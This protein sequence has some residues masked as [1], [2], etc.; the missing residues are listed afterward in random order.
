M[1]WAVP[2]EPDEVEDA[3]AFML[4][5]LEPEAMKNPNRVGTLTRLMAM[6]DYTRAELLLAMRKVPMDSRASHNYGR[7]FNPADVHRVIAESR[8]LRQIVGTGEARPRKLTE[9]QMYKACDEHEELNPQDFGT[10]GFDVDD[11]PFYVYCKPGHRPDEKEWGSGF[12]AENGAT[13]LLPDR[14]DEGGGPSPFRTVD[15]P[16]R[17]DR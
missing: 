16:G 2:A 11:R 15:G 8:K 7:G 10:C 4:T 5:T 12:G 13:A 3:T 17:V 14:T 6:Q 1:A 9:F